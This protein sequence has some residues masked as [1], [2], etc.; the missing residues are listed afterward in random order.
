MIL[1]IFMPF[2][3]FEGQPRAG[4]AE[5]KGWALKCNAILVPYVL[6]P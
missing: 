5:F 3:K 2:K 4:L 1:C 6:N